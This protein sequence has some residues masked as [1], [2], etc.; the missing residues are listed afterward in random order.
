VIDV[1]GCRLV[2][3]RQLSAPEGSITPVESGTDPVP[4]EVARV[5][6]V[7]DVVGGAVRAGHA[8]KVLEEFI[9]AVMGSFTVVMSDGEREQEVE[10]TRAYQGLYVPPRVWR[11]LSNFSSGAVAT[12]LCSHH[13]EEA[14]YIRDRDEFVAYV[15]QT[16]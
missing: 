15:R 7:Y 4:F 2:D 13:Y 14:D 9:V 11:S 6:Y 3:L 1:G 16:L 8:H 5:F 12:V 10:L